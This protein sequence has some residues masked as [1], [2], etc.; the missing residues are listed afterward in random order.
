[1]KSFKTFLI[2][3]F[4]A[5]F[6]NLNVSAQQTGAIN[7]QVFDSLGAV[8]SGATVIA[9]DAAAKEKSVVTNKEGAFSIKGLTPGKYTVRVVAPK[10]GLYENAEVEVAA[11]D[12]VELTVA[13]TIEAIKEEVQV[14]DEGQVSTDNDNNAGATVLKGKDLDSLPDDPDELEA[15]LQALA[16]PSAGPNGGQIYIDGFTGGRLPPKEAIREIR[17]NSN[18]FS[19]EFERLGFGRIEVLTRPGSDRFRGSTFFNFN[20]ESLNSRNPFVANRAPSQTRFY[21]GNISGPIKKGKASYFMDFTRRD[22][23]SSSTIN[24]SVLDSGFNV[25]PFRQDIQIPTRRTSFSPRIDFAI[26]QSNTLVARYSYSSFKS[27]N[28]GIGDLGL[29]SRA[30]ETSGTEHELRLTETAILNPKTVNE[31]RFEFSK[32]RNEQNGDNS[33]PTINVSGAFIGGGAQVGSNYSDSKR[34]E[35]TNYTTTSFGAGNQHSIK[36]G[37]RLR[38]VSIEDRSEA[39][40]GGTFTFTGFL[41]NRGTADTTDDV[42]VSSIEQYRQRLL[43]NT[44]PRYNPTQF[45]ITGGNPVANVSQYDVG[46]FITDDWK[47]RPDLTLSFGLRYENQTNISDGSNFAPR[48]SFAY[49]P[50]AGGARPPK[51]VFRGGAGIFYDRLGENYTLQA[52]RFDGA[53]QLQYILGTNQALLAQPV[54]S[55][56]GVTNVPTLAQITAVAPGTSTIRQISDDFRSPRVYQAV[57]S[58]ERQLPFRTTGAISYIVN[59]NINVLRSRNINAPVCGFNTVC[60]TTSAAIN[61]LRPNP[62][63]GNVYEYESTGILN[64]QQLIFNFNSRFSNTI[65]F[66]GNYRLGFSKSNADGGGA[67]PAYSY[68]LSNEYGNSLQD[69]RH[70]FVFFG[71]FQMPWNVRVNPFVIASSGRP[72][73][74][75]SGVDTNRDS[76]FNDRPT[77]TQLAN[78]CAQRGLTNDFC[79]VSGIANPNTTIIPR[80]YGRGPNYFSV[81]LS[82]NKSF[83]FGGSNR[84]VA[85]TDSVTQG[86]GS[87]NRG[88]RGGAGGG[89]RGGAGGG[90][91][92]GGG[93]Q[94]VMA[95]GGGGG[96]MVRQGGGGEGAGRYSLNFGVQINNLFNNVNLGTPVGNISSNRFGQSINTAGGFGGFGPGGFGGGSQSVNRSV[97]LQMR[98][99]F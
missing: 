38:G 82:I 72:F 51:T 89:N 19:A 44:D 53:Q 16:G 45:T 57:M 92:G 60:P 28:Q 61:A 17:I 88:G 33:L 41:D 43:G 12:P 84:A 30:F 5:A 79:D 62:A 36:F 86:G 31:T 4:L 93:Q 95:G 77:F 97:Q 66:G 54:F 20:D 1:M 85:Q 76:L 83:T 50:G 75:T 91:G 8:I 39:G 96:M 69:V 73:N 52:T 94:V 23:A 65:S 15:A 59:R 40:F 99:S 47:L 78:A 67:F 29:L 63:L 64:Q 21:G 49:S 32:R 68:D 55:L 90:G 27:E 24:A 10:F 81:N 3:G 2:L 34:F 14:G 18:P 87:G 70:N 98:F 7:G 71:S 9:V 11:G 37:G 58:V 74:I 6:L 13:L 42:F 56:N 22:G 35:L 26:N 25:V 80:N 48:F 46:L